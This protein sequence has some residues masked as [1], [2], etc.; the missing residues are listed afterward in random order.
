MGPLGEQSRFALA[1]R[2]GKVDEFMLGD[3]PLDGIDE[4]RATQ[5]VPRLRRNVYFRRQ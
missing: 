1:G 2:G 5:G 4:P 3:S